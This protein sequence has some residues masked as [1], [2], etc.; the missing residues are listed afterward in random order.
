LLWGGRHFSRVFGID[1]PH[2]TVLGQIKP[3]RQLHC[4][5][6]AINLANSGVRRTNWL[7]TLSALPTHF[8][9]PSPH[10]FL[11][12]LARLDTLNFWPDNLPPAYLV[13]L[14]VVWQQLWLQWAC[15]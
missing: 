15:R 11:A 13:Q 5:A 9:R 3:P 7:T 10:L 2:C 12:G 4:K 8:R 6:F 1:F 14:G